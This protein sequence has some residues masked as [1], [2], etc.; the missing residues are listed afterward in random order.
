MIELFDAQA[1]FGGA[2]RGQPWIPTVEELLGH[3]ARLSIRRALVRTDFEEMDGNVQLSNE[4]LYETCTKHDCLVPCPTLVPAGLGDVPSEQEQIDRLI[5]SGG[6]AAALRPGQDGWSTAEWC[7]GKLFSMLEDR[8]L[9]V[10]CRSASFPFEAL[11]ELAGR[12]PKLPLVIFQV[13]YR[14]QR[15]LVPLMKAFK[16][17]YLAVGSPYSVHRG[18]ETMTGQ[19]G[20]ERLL[21][22][23]G[24]P[25]ADM[26]PAV[27]MLTYAAVSETDKRLIGAENLDR[28]I[29]GIRK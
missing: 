26:M 10:L 5:A 23:T 17:L 22:G 16:N 21:F 27:T 20:A 8:R 28:L 18:V 13:G 3:M 29:G 2:R 12:Y 19:V 7:S 11:A 1:G 4:I 9:P 24:F 14:F 15:T 6:G 25:Y